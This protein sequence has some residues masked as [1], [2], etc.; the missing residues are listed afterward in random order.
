MCA[1][2]FFISTKQKTW[3][4]RTMKKIIALV[5]A[6]VC[7]LSLA[8][9]PAMAAEAAKT[10]PPKDSSIKQESRAKRLDFLVSIYVIK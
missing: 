4:D 7:V 10:R 5:M 6:L 1:G 9:T 3:E 2:A 8:V